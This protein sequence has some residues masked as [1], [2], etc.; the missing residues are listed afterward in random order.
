MDPDLSLDDTPPE[1]RQVLDEAE[2]AISSLRDD[3]QKRAEDL[4][5]RTE[6]ACAEIEAR[7][8]EQVEARQRDLLRALK[9][10]QDRYA[11][12]GKLDEALAIREH[13]RG[14]KAGLL[15]AREDP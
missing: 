5:A 9:P 12:E 6:Q 7:T 13:I 15:R 10:L 3:A 4:R 8:E 1:A 11:R 2:Q 14:L